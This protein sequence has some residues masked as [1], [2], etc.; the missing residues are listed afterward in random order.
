MCKDRRVRNA[1]RLDA[2]KEQMTKLSAGSQWVQQGCKLH[3]SGKGR[4]PGEPRQTAMALVMLALA[5]ASVVQKRGGRQSGFMATL[6]DMQ[7]HKRLTKNR[8]HRRRAE[9]LESRRARAQIRLRGE[10][11]RRY[12][13]RAARRRRKRREREAKGGPWMKGNRPAPEAM[14]GLIY[15]AGIAVRVV[16]RVERLGRVGRRNLRAAARHIRDTAARALQ[17][18]LAWPLEW[19]WEAEIMT[20]RLRCDLRNGGSLRDRLGKAQGAS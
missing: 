10:R 11:Q 7:R 19:A 6:A 20:D 12:A 16:H 5:K 18:I 15:M 8:R 4:S 14:M 2:Q 3:N 17:G 9:R 1:C 13:R